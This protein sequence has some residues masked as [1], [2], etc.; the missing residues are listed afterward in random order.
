M[1]NKVI[2]GGM[3]KHSAYIQNGLLCVD[4]SI[5]RKDL[6]KD[7]D[8]TIYCQNRD[9]FKRALQEITEGNY[10][11]TSDAMIQTI[12][13]KRD[14]EFVCS[15]CT[16][17]KYESVQSERTE[18]IFDDFQVIRVQQGQYIDGVNKVFV[19]G[20]ICSQINYREKDGRYYTK[21][22]LGVNQHTY[23]SQSAY[24]YIVSFGKEAEL[25][26]K[27]LGLNSRVF[28][29]GSI[30]ERNV[31]QNKDFVCPECGTRA[32]KRTPVVVREV[33]VSDVLYIDKVGKEDQKDRE[34]GDV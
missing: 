5:Y 29:T 30:Q 24:P 20:N 7:E 34:D 12:T 33:I 4:L 1:G 19:S 27:H 25:A 8:L 11:F 2:I 23:S 9:L 3:I 16:Y 18:V 28:V 17:T 10:F 14:K 15:E 26:H 22:K 21:Y 13:Y 32:I 6:R 31:K